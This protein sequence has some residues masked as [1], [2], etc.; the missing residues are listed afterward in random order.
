MN[1]SQQ[2]WLMKRKKAPEA[3][4]TP[5]YVSPG[6]RQ[7]VE[8]ELQLENWE[9]NYQKE[10]EYF[11]SAP[12][13]LETKLQEVL[14]ATNQLEGPSPLLTATCCE[15]LSSLAQTT[16]RS[17]EKLMSQLL[18]I[19]F[20]SIYD[21]YKG[22]RKLPLETM[23]QQLRACGE[24]YY[25]SS[26]SL[27]LDN[28]LLRRQVDM[29][30]GKRATM[31]DMLR[32]AQL[33]CK[34]AVKEW[35]RN[36]VF[37]FF[38]EWKMYNK[39]RHYWYVT[40]FKRARL[41]IW[42]DGLRY[43][44]NKERA[45]RERGEFEKATAAADSHNGA[46]LARLKA[47]QGEVKGYRENQK[48]HDV[49]AKR[50]QGL[51]VQADNDAQ[52]IRDLEDQL[53]SNA[54]ATA[55][56]VKDF[57]ADIAKLSKEKHHEYEW[58][59]KLQRQ[60]E[61]ANKAGDASGSGSHK[62][63]DGR[64]GRKAGGGGG[65]GCKAGGGGG[66]DTGVLEQIMSENSRLVEENHS[67]REQMERLRNLTRSL[68]KVKTVGEADMAPPAPGA[69][70]PTRDEAMKA[71]IEDADEGDTIM[72]MPGTYNADFELPAGV[73]IKAV[74]LGGKA[75]KFRTQEDP[76]EQERRQKYCVDFGHGEPMDKD[77]LHAQ[78]EK[79]CQ[80]WKYAGGHV[81]DI[82]AVIPSKTSNKC[83]P[84]LPSELAEWS[85]HVEVD[86][87]R[88]RSLMGEIDKAKTM[89][90]TME[91]KHAQREAELQADI[92]RMR[93][94]LETLRQQLA[95][96][97]ERKDEVGVEKEQLLDEQEEAENTKLQMAGCLS[98]RQWEELLAQ[99]AAEA[100]A[101][102]AE[103]EKLR[104]LAAAAAAAAAGG[105]PA[106]TS[107]AEV[108]VAEDG[109]VP[110]GGGKSSKKP[111]SKKMGGAKKAKLPKG[112]E[113][114][115]QTDFVNP[116][117]GAGGSREDVGSG[118]Y[119]GVH[120][121]EE[122]IEEADSGGVDAEAE[123]QKR[124]SIRF[125]GGVDR[126][127]GRERA[128]AAET[129]VVAK[130]GPTPAERTAQ[131]KWY[132]TWGLFELDGPL[133][134]KTIGGLHTSISEIYAKKVEA[135]AVDDMVG[136]EREAMSKFVQ[137]QLNMKYG[138]KAMADQHLRG[139]FTAVSKYGTGQAKDV[140][141]D[142]SAPSSRVELFGRL[143][144]ILEP[145]N[146][147][148]GAT[149]IVL[150]L[151]AQVFPTK[152]IAKNLGGGPGSSYVHAQACEDA[153][154]NVFPLADSAAHERRMNEKKHQSSGF[155]ARSGH[156]QATVRMKLGNP[157]QVRLHNQIR[158][159]AV[160]FEKLP[161]HTRK[162]IERSVT[163]LKQTTRSSV[164]LQAPVD[165]GATGYIDVDTFLWLGY[166]AW[167]EQHQHN[168][169]NLV[170]IF[171]AFDEDGDQR[172]GFEEFSKL[173]RYIGGRKPP[174]QIELQRMFREVSED[175]VGVEDGG[176]QHLTEQDLYVLAHVCLKH[177]V[178]ASTGSDDLVSGLV[179]W[180]EQNLNE[181]AAV[182]IQRLFRGHGARATPAVVHW[183]KA[184]RKLRAIRTV[185]GIT[186][187]FA[188]F[189]SGVGS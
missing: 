135:D 94:E 188:G 128:V 134:V 175:L 32:R 177:G 142:S 69:P 42:F 189:A 120:L 141:T 89:E 10:S 9:L 138:V 143:C 18:S 70:L 114:G 28:A 52:K 95:R 24:P 154:H 92:E 164:I 125:T 60:I 105:M 180:M 181:D 25:C 33:A 121:V 163:S 54:E 123:T 101:L 19:L 147:A 168:L 11:R 16:F 156:K 117:E 8:P 78:R 47:L 59:V 81:I 109:E 104:A 113:R 98:D 140:K 31:E 178:T 36:F 38:E 161:E 7:I 34:H 131:K 58:R 63:G 111:K 39:I 160:G 27:R 20:E 51:E 15:L 6:V 85:K 155:A 122:V 165:V 127:L 148:E 172:M 30:S 73:S 35:Q 71:S 184:W 149:D 173:M 66:G 187:S 65:G 115:T 119:A 80:L 99:S 91:A 139:I 64:G 46:L 137:E 3:I 56:A 68:G 166:S 167:E 136:H 157:A 14:S 124:N 169:S 77:T 79:I 21:D 49:I 151:L 90:A 82:T 67:L 158:N 183:R 72:L 186:A 162:R 144:G 146:S 150:E 106:A 118:S 116:A 76:K 41:R 88:I 37:R 97:E 53:K 22:V 152:S 129:A 74:A 185:T 50:L 159:A 57:Q 12:V 132:D 75:V 17:H 26:N 44:I 110:V 103:L 102:K 174:S 171:R 96:A 179:G 83:L 133:R 93:L 86:R 1:G 84:L 29:W 87:E 5:N 4:S 130:K 100:G 62:G 40:R 23:F 112:E 13:H 61:G 182:S 107:G 2:A 176:K 153:Y 145:E 48:K 126:G 55:H 45:Q 108:A 43:K 170:N